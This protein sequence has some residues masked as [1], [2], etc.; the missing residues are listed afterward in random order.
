MVGRSKD[1]LGWKRISGYPDRKGRQ[2]KRRD[3]VQR[4]SKV[5]NGIMKNKTPK[6]LKNAIVQRPD[7]TLFANLKT[8]TLFQVKK[9][10]D[11]TNE[12]CYVAQQRNAMTDELFGQK[13]EIWITK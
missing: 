12:S 2:G 1:D 9:T 6:W 3:T 10:I 4:F 7:G 13:Y 11:F 5:G 8:G